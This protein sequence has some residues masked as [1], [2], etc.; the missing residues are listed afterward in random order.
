M[1]FAVTFVHKLNKV[2]G[3]SMLACIAEPYIETHSRVLAIE[4]ETLK[5]V[6]AIMVGSEELCRSGVESEMHDPPTALFELQNLLCKRWMCKGSIRVI[7]NRLGM[8][9][10]SVNNVQLKPGYATVAFISYSSG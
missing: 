8:A 6:W 7:C 9:L 10:E 2:Q 3:N 1:E 5:L 4:G